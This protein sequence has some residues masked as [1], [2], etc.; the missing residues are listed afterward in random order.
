MRS[1]KDVA[2]IEKHEVSEVKDQVPS[3]E[4]GVKI[5]DKVNFSEDNNSERQS[6]AVGEQF[7]KDMPVNLLAINTE[8]K[9][10]EDHLCKNAVHK[11]CFT[12][13]GYKWLG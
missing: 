7:I 10:P 3:A 2:V 9:L 13:R 1:I 12:I 11:G 8:N 4:K 6:A 5:D